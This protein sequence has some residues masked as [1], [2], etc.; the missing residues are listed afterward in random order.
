MFFA[1]NLLWRLIWGVIGSKY[2]LWKNIFPGK[3]FIQL[4]KNYKSSMNNGQAQSFLGHNPLGRITV[5]AMILLM[6]VL[7]STG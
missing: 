2:A 1:F 6:V 4:L 7:M 3:G 5:S